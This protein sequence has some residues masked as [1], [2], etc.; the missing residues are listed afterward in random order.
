VPPPPAAVPHG[1]TERR[2]LPRQ[3]A[4]IAAPYVDSI[5][6]PR[7]AHKRYVHAVTMRSAG[8]L[9]NRAG[10]KRV[11]SAHVSECVPACPGM[12][13]SQNR[14]TDHRRPWDVSLLRC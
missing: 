12:C 7:H 10:A 9:R 5:A 2:K 14:G 11:L 6:R 1:V 13:A 8:A 3:L 4:A